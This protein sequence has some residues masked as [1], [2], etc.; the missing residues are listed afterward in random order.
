ME[1]EYKVITHPELAK[2]MDIVR[3]AFPN[4]VVDEDMEGQLIIYPGNTVVQ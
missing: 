3:K 2:L 4:A 1:N